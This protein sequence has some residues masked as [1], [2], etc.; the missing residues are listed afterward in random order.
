LFTAA[1]GSKRLLADRAHEMLQNGWHGCPG[2]SLVGIPRA[3]TKRKDITSGQPRVVELFEARHPR[4]KAVITEVDGTVHH[5][6]VVN[7]MRRIIIEPDEGT[8]HEHSVPR[9]VHVTVQEGERTE[10]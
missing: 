6:P 4:D 5:G 2:D 8:R 10:P 7:G 9:S 3:T 1:E